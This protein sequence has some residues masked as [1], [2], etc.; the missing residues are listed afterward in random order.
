MT[1]LSRLSMLVA[2]GVLAVP[3][4]DAAAQTRMLR[5]PTVSATQ[6]AFAYAQNIWIAPRAGGDA[7]RITS[8]QGATS[9]PH[10]SPDGK[11]LA[12][13]AEY[14]GNTDVYVV[15]ADGG[16][17]RRL[18]WHPSPDIPVGW[19]PDG[20]RVVFQSTRASDGPT[21]IPRFYTV[22]ATGGV[23]EPMPMPRAY[24]GQVSPDG[25]YV[26]YRMNN[27]WDE[28][29]R[30]YRGGQNRAIWIMDLKT[31]DVVTPPWTD[32]KDMEP[33]WVGNVVYF[34]SDRDGVSNVWSYDMATK[35][36]AQVTHFT[37]FDVK[38]LDS[39]DGVLVFEQG[40]EVHEL[41]PKTGREHVVNITVRGDFPWMMPHW[42]DVS[43]RIASLAISPTGKRALVEARGEIFT[44]PAEKGDVRDMT[45]SSGSA[46]IAPAWSPDGKFV[47][48]FSDKSGEYELVIEAQDGITPPRTIRLPNPTHYYTPEWSPDGKYIFYHDTN[49]HLWLLD[50]ATGQAKIIGNDPWMVP[51]RTMNPTWSPDSRYIAY[52]A[53]LSSLYKAIF[54]YDVQTGQTHQAT[55]GMADAVWPAFDA[56][57]KYLWFLA[58]TDF[59]L[60]SQWLDMTSYDHT[61][62]FGLYLT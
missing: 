10:F 62:T 11:W 17:P 61:E 23:V 50:V 59:G 25:R 26:A 8:F 54:V 3:G 60:R 53:H 35:K 14:E 33:A 24:Q 36:L 29:R 44:I 4:T 31:Y 58:S 57:G 12:F 9:D 18:T 39:G 1:R 2:A 37:G 22:P 49:L 32:S 30:N 42:T 52:V 28:E 55:D 21:A 19:T 41:D 51:Q 43:N 15:A 47:S 6:I 27:S 20:S 34:L 38:T 56:S 48:Y 5:S 46:E 40:G 13:A 16:Q 7:R 45:N